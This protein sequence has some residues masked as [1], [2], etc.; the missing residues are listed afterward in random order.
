MTIDFHAHWVPEEL[1]NALRKRTVPPHIAKSDVGEHFYMPVGGL[2]Y[3]DFYSDLTAR[4]EF[5]DTHEIQ[6]QVLSLPCLFGLLRLRD[7]V[8][9]SVG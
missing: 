9:L 3:D 7:P 5:M 8:R 6:T 4:L 1:A 2:P